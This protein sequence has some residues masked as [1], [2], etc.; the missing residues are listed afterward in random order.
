[1]LRRCPTTPTTYTRVG[2]SRLEGQVKNERLS[3]ERA[4]EWY[5]RHETYDVQEVVIV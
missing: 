3:Q 4:C 5:H 1:M 2:I